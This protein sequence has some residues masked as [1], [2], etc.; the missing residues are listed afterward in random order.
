VEVKSREDRDIGEILADTAT[1][2]RVLTEAVHE[3]LRRRKRL[4]EPVYVWRAGQVV[5]IAPED[6]P[7]R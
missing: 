4:G 6:I 5:R 3:A 2:Q 1:V 7:E